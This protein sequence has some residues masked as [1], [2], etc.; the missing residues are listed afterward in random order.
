MRVVALENW[1]EKA[2]GFCAFKVDVPPPMARA[3]YHPLGDFERAWLRRS[4]PFDPIQGKHHPH[5]VQMQ[6]ND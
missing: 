6:L 2:G 3:F 1:A 4:P 5:D